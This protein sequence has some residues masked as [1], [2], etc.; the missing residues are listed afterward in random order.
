[1]SRNINK[2]TQNL[3]WRQVIF[4]GFAVSVVAVL[5]IGLVL[6]RERHQRLGARKVALEKQ[7]VSLRAQR[8]NLEY[9]RSRHLE[10]DALLAQ[11]ARFNLGL[12]NISPSQRMTIE[13]PAGGD[14]ALRNDLAVAP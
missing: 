8:Q 14:A 12:T 10:K 2:S 13:R 9:L 3:R 6:E 5:T 11:A 1:M 7:A 4:A